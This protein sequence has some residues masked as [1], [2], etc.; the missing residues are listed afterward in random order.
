MIL[1]QTNKQRQEGLILNAG[2]DGDGIIVNRQFRGY[3]RGLQ[4]G[5]EKTVNCE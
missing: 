1:K 3:P 4:K 2:G 5:L